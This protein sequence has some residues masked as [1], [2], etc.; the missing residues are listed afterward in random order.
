MNWRVWNTLFGYANHDTNTEMNY[1]PKYISNRM[2]NSSK[3]LIIPT[4]VAS[5]NGLLDL[6]ILTLLLWLSSINYWYAPRLGWKRNIDI[7]CLTCSFA[8]HTFCVCFE[9]DSFFCIGCYLFG[10]ACS[11]IC[12]CIGKYFQINGDLNGDS[13]WHCRLHYVSIITNCFIYQ[14]IN[15]ARF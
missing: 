3:Y 2:L 11:G 14:F 7:L 6:A 9:L 15:E 5:Y 10:L 13:F 8:Y 1:Y 4:I 12:Y